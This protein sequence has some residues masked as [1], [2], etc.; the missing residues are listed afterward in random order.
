MNSDQTFDFTMEGPLCG[1]I[2]R[3]YFLKSNNCLKNISII[4]GSDIFVSLIFHTLVWEI[5]FTLHFSAKEKKIIII[6]V[7]QLK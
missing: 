1:L 5:M 2:F 7:V 4:L 6:L 3:Y